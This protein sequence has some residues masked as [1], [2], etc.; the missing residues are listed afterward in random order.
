VAVDEV[1]ARARLVL[2]EVE[3]AV[4]VAG[5][6]AVALPDAE[7]IRAVAAGRLAYA[8]AVAV[9]IVTLGDDTR[10]RAAACSLGVARHGGGVVVDEVVAPARLVGWSR[11]NFLGGGGG[12]LL[13]LLALLLALVG[14]PDAREHGAG[15]QLGPEDM[16]L[17]HDPP[18]G[19]RITGAVVS[20][21][22][23]PVPEPQLGAAA[24]AA[25]ND[26][27]RLLAL[28]PAPQAAAAAD[29]AARAAAVRGRVTRGPD[30]EGVVAAAVAVP[31]QELPRRAAAGI[32]FDDGV[33][34]WG[35]GDAGG[36]REEVVRHDVGV[37]RVELAR[38]R[39]RGV[40]AEP[41]R[42][43]CWLLSRLSS[44]PFLVSCPES[45]PP[46]RIT[47]SWFLGGIESR[48]LSWVLGIEFGWQEQE[49]GGGKLFPNF[50]DAEQV[51][52]LNSDSGPWRME[53]VRLNPCT[54][55]LP[56]QYSCGGDQ[57]QGLTPSCATRASVHGEVAE[58]ARRPPQS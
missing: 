16:V 17:V 52:G 1:A 8:A 54:E 10:L 37:G 18:A 20:Q 27:V 12:G 26:E 42:L 36:A 30:E 29:A 19:A 39:Q 47:L 48:S 51:I 2:V 4:A 57:R 21:V 46:I 25:R 33:R 32:V 11:G 34:V 9:A 7:E 6:V 15:E 22:V 13:L 58:E 14:D 24:A 40:E 28:L 5:L 53:K 55:Q 44:F 23:P 50:L 45:N 56:R 35:V 3:V 38:R 43:H 49:D 31:A 41:R